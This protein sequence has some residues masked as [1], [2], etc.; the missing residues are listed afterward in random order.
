MR[1]CDE[2]G[3]PAVVKV[4]PPAFLVS[5]GLTAF[6]ETGL[7]LLELGSCVLLGFQNRLRC[8]LSRFKQ[9][10]NHRFP[11]LGLYFDGAVS[12]PRKFACCGVTVPRS[13]FHL[14]LG[15]WGRTGW[16]DASCCNHTVCR[17]LQKD[18]ETKV[19]V[20]NRVTS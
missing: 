16:N 2:A 5:M 11:I 14:L 1:L 9:I 17:C 3:H 12:Q 6:E 7:L 10:P 19:A 8:K 20:E 18:A 15:H 4:D 13:C